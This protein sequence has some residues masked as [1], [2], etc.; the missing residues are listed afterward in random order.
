MERMPNFL[1]IGAAKTGTTSLHNY[2]GQHPEI[3]MSE[4]KE[5]GFFVYEGQSDVAQNIH[6]SLI[7]I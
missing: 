7:H 5:P 4:I 3:F 6:L 1:V 2:L